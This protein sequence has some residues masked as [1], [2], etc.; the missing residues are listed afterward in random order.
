MVDG[1]TVLTVALA[2][3]RDLD[4]HMVSPIEVS[5]GRVI[6]LRTNC[7]RAGTALDGAGGGGGQCRDF[8]L[9]NGY[10]RSAGPAV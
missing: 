10:T 6:S 7:R 2:N 3:F 8:A 5:A 4:Y 9:L 1:R